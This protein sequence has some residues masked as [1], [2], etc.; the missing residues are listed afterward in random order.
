MFSGKS[1]RDVTRG[2]VASCVLLVYG[3]AA[4]VVL[5][6]ARVLYVPQDTQNIASPGIHFRDDFLLN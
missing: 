5:C 3:S 6:Y 4:A 1:A 2:G